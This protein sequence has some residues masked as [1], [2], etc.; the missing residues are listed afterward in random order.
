MTKTTRRRLVIWS[1]TALIVLAALAV[2]LRP[3]PVPV[4]LGSVTTGALEVTLDHEGVTRVRDRFVVSAPVQG[5]VLRIDLEP[6]D[7]V[8]AGETVLARFLP[9]APVPLDARLR[10]E[11]RAR[12]KVARAALERARA[13]RA[14]AQ[15]EQD[16]ARAEWTRTRA[17]A[18]SGILSRQDR[19]RAEATVQAQAKAVEA[20]DAAVQAALHDLEAA[21]AALVEPAAPSRD[22]LPSPAGALA[23]RSPVSGVV[24]R[25]LRESEAV[26]APGEPLLE[27]A[28]SGELEV[29]ADYLSSDAV[30]IRAGMLARLEQWG[31]EAPIGG[32]VRRV[33]PAGFMK[34]SALGVEEQRVWVVIDLTDPRET[35]R[36]LGDGYRVQTR[37]V[38]WQRDG[39]LT[40]PTS[41]LFR[42]GDS[43]AAFVVEAGRAHVRL[44]EIGERSETAAEVRKGLAGGDRVVR[45][46]PDAVTEG[47]RVVER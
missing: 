42:Q 39:V 40:V 44:I 26:V 12:V 46:P 6:G 35:W 2:A 7:P 25:R 4:D 41:A 8:V 38:V 1:V 47:V 14:R 21:N 3:Q 22:G 29:V 20:A 45:H 18:D 13:E 5:R 10:A 33:E 11:S 34:I 9:A 31:G 23:L 43:W 36:A 15:A 24:L 32:R 37:V 16:L 28:D 17:L 30:R 27:V 19:D